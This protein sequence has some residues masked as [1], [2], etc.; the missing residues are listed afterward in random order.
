MMVNKLCGPHLIGDDIVKTSQELIC[1]VQYIMLSKNVID[2]ELG[3]FS[4]ICDKIILLWIKRF[5][6]VI[7]KRVGF[8]QPLLYLK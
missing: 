5:L 3:C 2:I 7:C 1:D 8:N 4:I 6:V